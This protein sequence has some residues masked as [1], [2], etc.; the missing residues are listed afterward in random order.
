MDNEQ[1]FVPLVSDTRIR[2]QCKMEEKQWRRFDWNIFLPIASSWPRGP[3]PLSARGLELAK[4][5][6]PITQ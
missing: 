1:T 4:T 5:E 3:N 2:Y 6:T